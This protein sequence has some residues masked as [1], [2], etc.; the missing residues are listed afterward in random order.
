MFEESI[1]AAIADTQ[2]G[3]LSA[4][5]WIFRRSFNLGP[6]RMN[7]SKSGVGGSFGV[8]PFRIGRSATGRSYTSTRIP[9]TGISYRTS[10]GSRSSRGCVPLPGCGCL[11]VVLLVAI[12][13]G[14]IVVLVAAF[15]A[16]GQR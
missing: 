7:V 6:F 4:M 1:P 2:G 16:D 11:S 10:S 8:G 14:G 3:W 15:G 9:G 13:L 5:G 12:V